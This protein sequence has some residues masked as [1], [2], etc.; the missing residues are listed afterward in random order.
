MIRRLSIDLT[1]LPPTIEEVESFLYD[2]RPNAYE[3]LVDRLLHS[4]HFGEHWARWW[5]DLAHYADS[6]GYLQDFIR[7]V[8]WR[9]RQWVIDAFNRDQP[10]DQFTIEQ[11]AGDLISDATTSQRMA[12][13]FLRNTLSNREGGA[14]LEEFRVRQVIDRTSTTATT[15]LAL[16]FACAECH[17]HKF[18]PISQREF[19]QLYAFFN[20]ADEV[21]FDAP[22]PGEGEA[23]EKVQEEYHQ[24]R[25][26]ILAQVAKPLGE[27]QAEWE[28][29][30][31]YAELHPGDDFAWDRELELLGLQWGQD[32][33][34][35]QL[36]GLNILK[37]PMDQRNRDQQDRVLDYFLKR[38]DTHFG[39]QAKV[40]ELSKIQEQL[41]ALQNKQ[42]KV[43][44]APGMMQCGTARESHVH[45][46]GNYLRLRRKS[47]SRYSKRI[48][49]FARSRGC[50]PTNAC[51]MASLTR[52]S[53]NG[54]GCCKPNLAEIIW[55]WDCG[56]VR[57]FWRPRRKTLA[58][59]IT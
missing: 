24:Q 17:D 18:D 19:Y 1:G 48:A 35:G 25:T 4:E 16:T 51:P 26:S 56:V 21:N 2:T 57:K 9:Y 43:T 15:W 6:D 41:V 40:L 28:K 22:L 5:L 39:D 52:A 47:C 7:P 55:S 42:P 13:G 33:G 11:L 32:L 20:T 36:E 53:I 29:K 38:V 14:D 49:R 8:A 37:I 3:L 59:R 31:L 30:I 46:R 23:W 45:I 27:L 10:F 34:E 12:T 44:R 58:P 54:T 50:K